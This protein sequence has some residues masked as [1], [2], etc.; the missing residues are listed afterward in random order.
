MKKSSTVG[1][2]LLCFGLAAKGQAQTVTLQSVADTYLRSGSPN[3]NQGSDTFLRIQ[4]SGN[5]R[6]LV[7]FDSAAITAAVGNGS[8][9]SARLELYIQSNS[10][11]WDTEGRT[12][13]AHRL[14]SSWS[15][16]GATWNC[17]IDSNPGNS[18]ADCS[19][20]WAGGQFAE[21]PSDTVLHTN[22]L[23]GW[24]RF[25]VTADVRAFLS[26]TANY[27]WIVKKTEES[28]NGQV[29][30]TSRQGA[31]DHAPRLVLVVESASF[32]QVPPALAITA[33]SR[34]TLINEPS[35]TVTVAYTDGGSGIDTA[36][37]QLLVDGQDAT[38]GCT[39]GA[40][41]ATCHPAALAAGAHTLQAKVRD[42]AGNP[43]QSSFSFQLLLGP[44]PHLVTLQAVADAY[45]RKGGPNQNQGTEPILR[46]QQSGS[47]RALVQL[48]QQSL[49][50]ALA[51][52]TLVSAALELHVRENGRNWGTQG[53]TVDVHRLTEAWTE[54]GATWS[55]PADANLS[56]SQ[57]DCAAQWNGGSFAPAPTASVLHTNNL[58]GWVSFDVTSD[59]AAFL[60]GTQNHGWLL[61]KTNEG[62]AGRMDYDS[63]QGTAGEGPRLVVVF[64][65]AAEADT[66]PPTITLTSPA[67]G[68][69][70]A[71]TTPTLRATYTDAGSG[72]NTASVRL[73]LDDVDRTSGAQI[74]ASEVTLTP[75]PL[76]P[77]PHSATLAVSDLAGNPS[78]ASWSFSVD[79]VA[80]LLQ[81]VE[82]GVRVTLDSPTYELTVLYGDPFSSV[83]LASLRVSIDAVDI[84]SACVRGPSSAICTTPPLTTGQHTA[85]ASL[86]DLAGNLT[87]DTG[88]LD[89]L[90]DLTPP[91][92]NL[93]SPQ[94]GA[95]VASTPLPV[96]GSV[97]DDGELSLLTV[98]G[99]PATPSGG[100]FSAQVDLTEGAN[101][102]R[103]VATD[104][105]G[106]QSQ[107]FAAVVLDT[108][109]PT[110]TVENPQPGSLTNGDS[111][112]VEG[113]ADD[114]NGVARV[115]VAGAA[116]PL[117]D[118]RFSQLL[119][120]Q[121]GAN[122]ITLQ[123][124]DRAGNSAVSEV[125]VTRFNLPEV[126]ITSP[127][128]L[129]WIAAT[130]VT[131]TGTVS[132]GVATVSLNG[133]PAILS[134]TTFSASGVPLLEGGN[135]L[136][137][138]AVDTQGHVATD[139]ISVVRDLT[140]PRLEIYGPA[141]GA[142]VTQP[143][144]AVF[145]LV[146]DIVPG[147]VNAS[148]VTVTVNGHPAEVANRSF[149]LPALTLAEGDN[150]IFVE[151]TDESGNRDE[152]R[153]SVRREAPA[154]RRLTI[155]SGDRQSGIIGTELPSP[156]VV[157]VLDATGQSVANVPVLFKV[158]GNNG[159]LDGGRRQIA[160]VTDATGKASARFT[161]GTRMGV[162]SQRIEAIAVG[163]GSVLFLEDAQ[164]GGATAIVVDSG[165]QQVGV[166]G[167]EL[168]R[169]LVAVVTDAG[170]NRLEAVPVKFT[171][172][173]GSGGFRNGLQ[174]IVIETDSDGRAIVPFRLDAQEGT[175]ANV[176][177][178]KIDALPEGPS[179]A[180]TATG[181]AAGEASQT[182]VKG[183]VLDNSNQPIPGVTIRIKDTPI[184]VQ[185]DA[186]GTFRIQPAPVGTF[187][188]IV[189]G[190]TTS[191][192]GSWP[193]LEFVMTTVSGREIDLGMPIYLLPLN[194]AAGLLVDE[195]H[196][197]TITLPEIPGF[198]LE[199]KPGSVTFPGGSRSGLVSVTAVHADKVPMVPNFGQ[200]PRFIVTIQPAGARFDP[201]AR[202]T[203]P[204]LEGLA[205]GE[206]TEMYSFDHDLGHFVSIGPATVSDDGLT[207]T[208]NPGVGVIKAGWHCGGNPASSGT[209]HGCPICTGC[210]PRTDTCQADN[211]QTPPQVRPDDCVRQTCSGG[212]I[213][214]VTNDSETPHQNGPDDCYRQRCE[215]G[216]VMDVIATN[217]VP[218][219]IPGNCMRETCDPF[220][221]PLP[222]DLTDAPPGR[223]CCGDGPLP[224]TTFDLQTQCCSPTTHHVVPRNPMPLD[225]PVECPN[226][227]P[228][229]RPIPP[230]NGCGPSWFPQVPENPNPSCTGASFTPAC[231]EHDNCWSECGDNFARCNSEFFARMRAICAAANCP[232]P[233]VGP[234]GEIISDPR[235]QC[236][237]NAL[238]YYLAVSSNTG[239][240]GWF[241]GQ[242]DVCNCC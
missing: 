98:N 242:R 17:G 180:F 166:A 176:V 45:L 72:I 42:H 145:G 203:L 66:T 196:G 123:A 2:L 118:G 89:L 117:E 188:L 52:A 154:G 107:A 61:K 125:A 76:L 133:A 94:D 68:S 110:L 54:T 43:A 67:N 21:E 116:V 86:R 95:L 148:E 115:E 75:E 138:S 90:V 183:V 134:G 140:P 237:T 208:S 192:P 23:S 136:T 159:T 121:G 124:F 62:Q 7:R 96:T 104:S 87:E 131:V 97:S 152:A 137:A 102:I 156:L 205:P 56:N 130:T 105:I 70:G 189:D 20:Q 78:Q 197:G 214:P 233:V 181:W 240:L 28:Q 229:G 9:A 47:N 73:I 25:D 216:R 83:D 51:G 111:I 99:L 18:S 175:A 198:A 77:G 24:I 218:P 207:I 120:V 48:D 58:T 119:P 6:S 85:A 84:S 232:D 69:V 177:T 172:V 220:F 173:K 11:N 178:A 155:V 217:E 101:A 74:S 100:S 139:T 109:P 185:T 227:V 46:V 122:L 55:C 33:P 141:A 182:A 191:Q 228:A 12:V 129:S 50:T 79:P 127:D 142:V 27:G 167:Q 187:Y 225:W 195:T 210:D 239:R 114:E 209:T 59:V 149:V 179:A 219:Q 49:A 160:V 4:S 88:L 147:T 171:V 186:Q 22:G 165:D 31:A 106:R 200:Q 41:S 211:S 128:D 213:V 184:T 224:A 32:D 1:L 162:A 103:V 53:R 92:L 170:H 112:R 158:S 202:L 44:G 13:D 206:V 215:H 223:G 161:L 153:V 10:N 235:A 201:P 190:S 71:S 241:A 193:D 14:T 226:R 60:S 37:F 144:T 64:Q 30:Y 113:R 19:T 65:T 238:L 221:S 35:P 234:N 82:P 15:E 36:S 126:T 135:L 222:I 29:E 150:E 194:E 168:P 34:T 80:P 93:V 3:Q 199:I 204:N 163:Y 151:A 63:R 8:L 230:P 236:Y 16:S 108:H 26:G 57:P 39:A 40:Q 5:N 169:P 231:N 146:N 143:A 91:V 132:P 174:E 157:R 38:A 81:I 212:R 164:P